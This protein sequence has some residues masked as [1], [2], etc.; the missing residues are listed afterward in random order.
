MQ[1]K[2]VLDSDD[3]ASNNITLICKRLNLISLI[4]VLGLV[5]HQR[6]LCVTEVILPKA[7][8]NFFPTLRE[9]LIFKYQSKEDELCLF[10]NDWI[11]KLHKNP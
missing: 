4:Q 1:N 10:F 8:V 5:I 7:N 2:Y 3:K 11:S 9:L 6:T